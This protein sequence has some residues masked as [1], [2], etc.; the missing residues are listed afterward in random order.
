VVLTEGLNGPEWQRKMV[1]DEVR[2]A[3]T[4]GARGE[5]CCRGPPGSWTPWISSE[6]CC[7]GNTGV[8]EYGNTPAVINFG[9]G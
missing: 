9:R 8:R 5:G 7:E 2:A 1:G 6:W 4:G 3:E